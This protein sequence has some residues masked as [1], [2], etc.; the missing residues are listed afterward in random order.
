MV[1]FSNH[2]EVIDR[3]PMIVRKR[4][5][6]PPS[7]SS[8]PFH[9]K[10]VDKFKSENFRA[11]SSN[12]LPPSPPP[13][14]QPQH[15][16]Q[17]HHHP[18]VQTIFTI[19]ANSSSRT[20]ESASSSSFRNHNIPPQKRSSY[21]YEIFN[22]KCQLQR[23]S[24]NV[25]LDRPNPQTLF[26]LGEPQTKNSIKGHLVPARKHFWDAGNFPSQTQSKPVDLS[27][28]KNKHLLKPILKERSSNS[29]RIL[30]LLDDLVKSFQ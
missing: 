14:P 11:S 23:R 25:S 24:R 8:I 18:N 4:N 22:Q 3:A 21:L 19:M 30:D 6:A 28:L 26:D 27:R 10:N 29:K 9:P 20:A 2:L 7:S 5:T 1:S 16:Q 12:N 13:P 15:Q 17:H